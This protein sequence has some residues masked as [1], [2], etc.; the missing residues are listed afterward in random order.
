MNRYKQKATEE[1]MEIIKIFC[2]YIN[3]LYIG[4]II[5]LVAGLIGVWYLGSIALGAIFLVIGVVCLLG[6]SFYTAK[7]CVVRFDI[8]KRGLG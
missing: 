7:Y 8:V 5:F 1:E 6:G 4:F 3:L 2:R